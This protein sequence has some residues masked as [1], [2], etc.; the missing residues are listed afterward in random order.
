MQASSELFPRPVFP[1][2]DV[3]GHLA[4]SGV[5]FKHW[6]SSELNSPLFATFSS[7][8]F[9]FFFFFFLHVTSCFSDC[10]LSIWE[11]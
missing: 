1:C 6:F 3:I 10:I 2:C 4:Q 8:Y 11:K 5:S 7:T 9:F